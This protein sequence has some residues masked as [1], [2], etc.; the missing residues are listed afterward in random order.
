MLDDTLITSDVC[1]RCAHCCKWQSKTQ[2]AT[3]EQVVFLNA[4]VGTQQKIIWHNPRN[5]TQQEHTHHNVSPFEIE[6][7]CSKLETKGDLKTCS[8]YKDRPNICKDYNC[9]T[10]SN[11]VN[12]RPANWN[13]I[14]RI[15]KE[16]HNVD[17]EYTGSLDT[18]TY[19]KNLEKI[20]LF[21]IK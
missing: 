12:K 15:I 17:I 16:V 11:K 7:T 21:E 19:D 3:P 1:Q 10:I 2:L 8:I 20:G 14:K 5:L 6:Y 18:E 9:F 4:I 13:N